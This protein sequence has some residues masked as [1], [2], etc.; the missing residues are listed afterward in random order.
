MFRL[1]NIED[2]IRVLNTINQEIDSKKIEE[3]N[4][5]LKEIEEKI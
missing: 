5:K 4:E 2:K 3:V 1:D